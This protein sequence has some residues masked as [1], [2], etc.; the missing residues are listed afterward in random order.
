MTKEVILGASLVAILLLALAA[1]LLRLGGAKLA[2]K[3]EAREWAEALLSGFDGGEVWL[4]IDGASAVVAGRDGSV[5]MVRRHGARFIARRLVRPARADPEG[6]VVI[7]AS[8]ERLLKPFVI[9]LAS[10]DDAR[11]LAEMLVAPAP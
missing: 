8:G 3:E 2:S 1:K 10:D 6:P 11:A 7:V 5:A 9:T 4:D